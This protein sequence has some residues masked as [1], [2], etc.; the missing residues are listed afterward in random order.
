[1]QKTNKI[2]NWIKQHKAI[3]IIS[4][5]ATALIGL[6]TFTI[7]RVRYLEWR[8]ETLVNSI[9]TK[10]K[11][12]IDLLSEKTDLIAKNESCVQISKDIM[13]AGRLVADWKNRT[14]DILLRID[15]LFGDYYRNTMNYCLINDDDAPYWMAEN[16]RIQREYSS[17]LEEY[18]SLLNEQ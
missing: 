16:S 3:I 13:E 7:I 5:L 8:E 4:I 9:N 1:M 12:N 2:I 10:N 14:E 15:G 17:I 18:K 11:E 6:T